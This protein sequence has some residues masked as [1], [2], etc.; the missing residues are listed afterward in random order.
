LKDN[1]QRWLVRPL[2][3]LLNAVLERHWEHLTGRFGPVDM[4]APVPS[5][6]AIRDGYDHV[7]AIVVPYLDAEWARGRLAF[8]ALVR[9]RPARDGRH[10]DQA[11]FAVPDGALVTGRRIALLDDT[12]T[13]GATLASA[14][15]ALHGAG[16]ASVIGVTIG[17][18]LNLD[19]TLTPPL[20]AAQSAEPFDLE[21]C[22]L[23]VEQASLW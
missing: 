17:R 20:H 18:Q 6:P 4:V 7:R 5:H 16:A 8:D 3:A 12:F 22:A 11:L 19:Y 21:V 9:T 23:E 1:D 2:G 13:R 15:A 10:V 14:A